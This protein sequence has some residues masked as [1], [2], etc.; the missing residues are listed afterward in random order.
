MLPQPLPPP[1]VLELE[2]AD[3]DPPPHESPHT[4]ATSDTHWLSHFVLQQYG[5][6]LQIDVAHASQDAV[7]LV[8]LAQTSCA[9]A[10][11]PPP[12][13]ELLEA[14]E[15]ELEDALVLEELLLEEALEL[16]EPID[17]LPP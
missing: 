12:V 17:P 6:A 2:D 7:S 4:D 9:H 11:P 10:A 13:D 14:L 5:S 3:V 16:L 8:P 15:L 1:P